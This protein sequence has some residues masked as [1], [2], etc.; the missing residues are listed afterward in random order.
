M[1]ERHFLYLLQL[2]HPPVDH[3]GQT[4]GSSGPGISHLYNGSSNSTYLRGS[5][6]EEPSTGPGN[7]S[8]S[9][10]LVLGMERGQGEA[11]MSKTDTAFSLWLPGR[12]ANIKQGW[13]WVL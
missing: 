5:Y 1:S 10:L 9:Y 6:N 13:G 7:P 8:S 12:Q 11:M 2:C 3:P 4:L